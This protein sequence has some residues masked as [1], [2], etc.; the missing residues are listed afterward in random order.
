MYAVPITSVPNQNIAFNIDGGYW[1]VHIYQSIDFMCADISLNGAPV[2]NGVRCF[3]GI[4]L[5]PYEYMYQ[6]N[7]GNF[8][9]DS[10]ADWTNFGASCNLYYLESAEYAAFQE[11]MDTGIAPPISS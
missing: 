8:V 6:P 10:D 1:Q 5:M 2:I 9:F 11:A 3:G 4:A 7:Y